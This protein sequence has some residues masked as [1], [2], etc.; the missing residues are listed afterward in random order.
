MEERRGE[1]RRGEVEGRKCAHAHSGWIAQ[2]RVVAVG[3]IDA[4]C[5]SIAISIAALKPL[6]HRGVSTLSLR[7]ATVQSA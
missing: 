7:A 6:Q 5:S 1:E 4:C 3:K 2:G